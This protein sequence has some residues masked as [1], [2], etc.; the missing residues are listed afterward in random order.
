MRRRNTTTTGGQSRALSAC[1]RFGL[2]LLLTLGPYAVFADTLAVPH[3]FT[4]GEVAD[5]NEVNANFNAVKTEVDDNDGRIDTLLDQSCPAGEVV[6]GVD[7]SGSIVCTPAPPPIDPTCPAG[8]NLRTP[9]EVMQ[10]LRASIA[11]LDSEALGCNFD[12]AARA[13]F[14]GQICFGRTDITNFILSKVAT[15]GGAN[16]TLINETIVDNLVRDL[17]TIAG[18]GLQIVDGVSTYL[19]ENGQIQRVTDHGLFTPE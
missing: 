3:T 11:A 4:N 12:L 16:E 7:A 17:Y 9:A 15:F 2:L 10:D 8:T 6:I 19:I 1:L 18:G 13:I 5:A 14:F